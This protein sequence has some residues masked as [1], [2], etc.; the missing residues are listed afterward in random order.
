MRVNEACR[1]WQQKRLTQEAGALIIRVNNRNLANRGVDLSVSERLL[2]R[3]PADTVW[4]AER[5]IHPKADSKRMA[6]AGADAILVGTSLMT[7]ENPAAF[8]AAFRDCSQDFRHEA[9]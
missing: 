2:P 8:V 7:A 5:G 6:A 4:V 3:T 9:A 1:G